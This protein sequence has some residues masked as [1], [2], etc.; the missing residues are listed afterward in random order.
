M[1]FKA[2]RE[3]AWDFNQYTD[4]NQHSMFM[5]QDAVCPGC[6]PEV[7]AAVTQPPRPPAPQLLRRPNNT[8][9]NEE[10]QEEPP[11]PAATPQADPARFVR[12]RPHARL[13][14]HPDADSNEG[15][16]SGPD[17]DDDVSDTGF[18]KPLPR[19]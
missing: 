13:E 18:H 14:P 8:T 2:S 19:R 16:G 7:S 3:V 11:L 15:T 10:E 6:S 12:R 9:R 17:N 5:R 1:A 4:F